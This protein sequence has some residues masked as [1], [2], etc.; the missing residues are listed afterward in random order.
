M[1]T[2]QQKNKTRNTVKVCFDSLCASIFSL[3]I[4]LCLSHHSLCSSNCTARFLFALALNHLSAFSIICLFYPCPNSNTVAILFPLFHP[5]LSS[6]LLRSRSTYY[7]CSFHL[8]LFELPLVSALLLPF[9]LS[10]LFPL[11]EWRE[12]IPYAPSVA[13]RFTIAR[14][15]N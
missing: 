5:F 7:F 12:R 8:P 11:S 4:H 15:Q 9:F 10:P 3:S 2:C 13:P 1:L 14:A 6:S